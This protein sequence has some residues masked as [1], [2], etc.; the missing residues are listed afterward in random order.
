VLRGRGRE[1]GKGEGE[2]DGRP[3]GLH[4]PPSHLPRVPGEE[5]TALFVAGEGG[6]EK[7]GGKDAFPLFLASCRP[8]AVLRKKGRSPPS[9]IKPRM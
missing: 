6:K 2:G 9:F 1:R 3:A 5:R 8:A 4:F 7:E